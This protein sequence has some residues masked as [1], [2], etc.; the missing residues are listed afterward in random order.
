VLAVVFLLFS[1]EWIFSHIDNLQ[2]AKFSQPV[3]LGLSSIVAFIDE[4]KLAREYSGHLS[5][6]SASLAFRET[7]NQFN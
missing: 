3:P 7:P 2:T 4:V 5:S 1:F 6:L